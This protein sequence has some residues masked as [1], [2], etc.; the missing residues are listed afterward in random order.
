MQIGPDGKIYV[1]RFT[2]AYLASIESPDSLGNACNFV[3]ASVPL[4]GIGGA[5]GL[6]N[7][8]S[9]YF[10]SLQNSP[11]AA[12]TSNNTSLCLGEC[13]D[14]FDLTSNNPMTW[15]WFFPGADS[16]GSVLQNPSSICYS[17]PGS[18]NVIL[19][20]SNSSGSD[21]LTLYNFITVNPQPPPQGIQ[22]NGDTLFS[23]VGAASYQWYYNGSL[24]N[25]ATDYFYLALASG[26]YN[27]VVSDTN[28]CEVEA[29]I[30]NVI[31]G[32]QSSL[33]E[34]LLVVYPNPVEDQFTMHARWLSESQFTRG[35][36]VEISIYNILG[37]LAVSLPTANCFLPTC[38]IDV[39]TLP[40]GMYWLEVRSGEKVF[41]SKFLKE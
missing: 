33:N 26:D 40:K 32:I 24:I 15:Q 23:N 9:S 36:V 17:T 13:T 19:I 34:N 3:Y 37:E 18:Y 4:I 1:G 27:V 35:T 12:F 6:P 16:A 7:F 22:Q 2:D 25:G 38:S 5:N 21:T 8:M 39:H 41:R 29:A 11:G 14:F 31:A 10:C 30:F 28:G 20:A